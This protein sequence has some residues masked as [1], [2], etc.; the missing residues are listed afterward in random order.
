[1]N[2][3]A[4]IL[5]KKLH[6]KQRIID[7]VSEEIS[8]SAYVPLGFKPILN[9]EMAPTYPFGLPLLIAFF[10]LF[11]D[12][13]HAPEMVILLHAIA[14]IILIYF[15]AKEFGLEKFWAVVAS[16]LLAINP[17]FVQ[18]FSWLMSDMPAMFWCSLA[19]F[20]ALK[21]RQEIKWAIVSGIAIGVAVMI[22]PTNILVFIPVLM[23]LGFNRRALVYLGFA[24]FPFAVLQGFLNYQCYG[25]IF[26]TGYGDMSNFFKLE[27]VPKTFFAYAKY[28]FLELTPFVTLA[29]ALLWRRNKNNQIII[30]WVAPF[31]IFYSFYYFTSETWW[32]MRFVLPAFP[33][34]IL[35]MIL[36]MRDVCKSLPQ[37]R[38]TLII[39]FLSFSFFWQTSVILQYDL[40]RSNESRYLKMND[41]AE[42]NLPKNAVI[43]AMQSS[44]SLFYY[45]DFAIVRYDVLSQDELNKINASSKPFYAMLHNFELDQIS[46]FPGNWRK[47]NEID[48]IAIFRREEK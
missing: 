30:F 23:I 47:E 5:D 12:V 29:L 26:T 19:I 28:L 11:F 37:L 36:M 2:D 4:L 48:G 38:R 39:F 17:L 35:A 44:G 7:D 6:A 31:L 10:S 24:G 13:D 45:T 22:R 20:S 46:K 15:L 27:F 40:L 34:I 9:N 8:A 3:V 32:Y 14:S 16:I 33:A 42:E 18:S 43:F 25:E 41:W 21:T 1:M